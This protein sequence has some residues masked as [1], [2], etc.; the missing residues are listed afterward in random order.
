MEEKTARL[1]EIENWKILLFRSYLSCYIFF[2]PT[3]LSLSLCVLRMRIRTQELNSILDDAVV[4]VA[5]SSSYI[6]PLAHLAM[7]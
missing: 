6:F 4:C 1:L 7:M 2:H 5:T 3:F